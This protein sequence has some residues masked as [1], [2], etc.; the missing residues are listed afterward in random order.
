MPRKY[1]L[2]S[3]DRMDACLITP[4][5]RVKGW[6]TFTAIMPNNLHVNPM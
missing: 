6:H 4:L 2:S 5:Q 3:V 1:N